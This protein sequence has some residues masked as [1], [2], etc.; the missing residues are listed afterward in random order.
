M[1]RFKEFCDARTHTHTHTHTH[2]DRHT[3]TRAHV[4]ISKHTHK[5]TS[6]PT[7]RGVSVKAKLNTHPF[8]KRRYTALS[9]HSAAAP[10]GEDAGAGGLTP[11]RVS[12]S[13][14]GQR[15]SQT[16]GPPRAPSRAICICARRNNGAA[17]RRRTRPQRRSD[18]Q[19]L[20]PC[21]EYV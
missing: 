12:L 16:R 13:P 19:G 17:P 3:R 21:A 6:D 10:R 9:P 18:E 2:T 1:K 11:R 4:H 7:D 15:S 5:H 20:Q 8:S 14:A